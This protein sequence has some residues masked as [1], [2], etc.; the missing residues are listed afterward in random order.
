M[1]LLRLH[2]VKTSNSILQYPKHSE[3]EEL[4]NS[5]GSMTKQLESLGHQLQVTLLQE[6]FEGAFW[7]RYTILSLNQQAVVIACSKAKTIDT[8]FCTLLQ[9]ANTQPIGKFLFAADSVVKRN[10]NMQITSVNCQQIAEQPLQKYLQ[11]HYKSHQNFWLR[12]SYF[13]LENQR[14][15]LQEI[16]LPELNSFFVNE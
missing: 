10:Q 4:L 13:E 2:A 1:K 3:F 14:L 11:N 7:V 6:G 15:N 5:C 12:D 9:N 8:F 16:L